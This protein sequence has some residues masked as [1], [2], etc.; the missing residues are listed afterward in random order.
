MLPTTTL[1]QQLVDAATASFVVIVVDSDSDVV[2]NV[3]AVGS[4]RR[5]PTPKF[6]HA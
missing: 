5:N 1:V 6:I 3:V 2:V 4:R